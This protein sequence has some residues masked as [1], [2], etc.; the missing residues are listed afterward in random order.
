MVE[1]TL[2]YLGKFLGE[3]SGIGINKIVFH[4]KE[5]IFTFLKN[6]SLP[7]ELPIIS[8][9]MSNITDPMELRA[10]NRVKGDYNKNFTTVESALIV[11]VKLD[12]TI[13][14]ISNKLT[15]YFSLLNFYFSINNLPAFDVVLNSDELKGQFAASITDLNSLSTPAAGQEGKDYD[16]GKYYVLEGSFSI[17]TYLA[18]I[19][20]EKVVRR[21]N[22]GT[23]LT[24]RINLFNN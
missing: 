12:I 2:S 18:Y 17:Y 21:I 6:N 10:R 24:S 19:T 9:Y 3:R 11:P 22:F 14:L 15:D 16:R 4:E 23:N 7:M 8:Y 1:A 13:A 5:Q 20:E